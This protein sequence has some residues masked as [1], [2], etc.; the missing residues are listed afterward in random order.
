[1]S[2]G[3]HDYTPFE[4]HGWEGF[5]LDNPP[6]LGW[7]GGE[8]LVRHALSFPH[9]TIRDRSGASVWRVEAPH[10]A[11]FV[12]HFKGLKNDPSGRQPRLDHKFKW[13]YRLSR[14]IHT[15]KISQQMN[16]AGILTP[17]VVLAAR[18][19]D[20]LDATDV[21]IT[22]PVEGLCLAKRLFRTDYY[23]RHRL[24]EVAGHEIARLHEAGFTHGD[25][26]PANVFLTPD[27]QRLVFLDNDRTQRST[28][29]QHR[30]L[31]QFLYRVLVTYG[32]EHA[33][34]FMN[35]YDRARNVTDPRQRR[36]RWRSLLR[37]VSK[38]VNGQYLPL[39]DK[40]YRI[41]DEPFDK[42]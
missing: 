14:A 35:A 20:D 12:K 9:D 8:D 30:N 5:H 4:H 25:F 29:G 23:T 32:Y 24:L 2:T 19:L 6:A 36:R 41:K 13:R 27:D 10:G 11:A 1:M 22:E 39:L 17:H 26:L 42:T 21:L 18:R 40:S 34:T 28:R 7:I 31:T 38:R 15:L 33:F 37:D 16:D 3:L